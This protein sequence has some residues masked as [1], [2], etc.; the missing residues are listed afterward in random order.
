MAPDYLRMEQQ[1]VLARLL[2]ADGQPA[3]A[4][5]WL[6]RLEVFAVERGYIRWL[7]SVRILQALAASADDQ[8]AQA[9]M[10]EALTLAV[11]EDYQRPFLDE[12][13]QVFDLLAKLRPHVPVFI[14]AL[15]EAG[16]PSWSERS[17]QALRE[18]LSDAEMN[19]LNMVASGLSNAEIGKNLSLATDTALHSVNQLAKKL[20]ASSRTQVVSLARRLRRPDDSAH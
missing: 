17:M 18:T 5:V 8:R 20:G 7:I 3:Q 13:P 10:L 14:D 11:D 9:L 1:I 19:L 12:A 16:G 2:L 4:L 15:F 6:G